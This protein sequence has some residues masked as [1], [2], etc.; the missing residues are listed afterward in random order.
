MNIIDVT[1]RESTYLPNGMDEKK[2]LLFLSRYVEWMQFDEIKGIEICFLDNMKK[3]PLLYDESFILASKRIVGDRFGLIAVVHP[4]QVDLS[5]WNPDIVRLFH[6]VRLMINNTLDQKAIDI[7]DYLHDLGVRVSLNVIYISR[8]D[9]PFVD[10][11]ISVAE[12]HKVEYF[13]LADSCGGCSPEKVNYWIGFIQD[14]CRSLTLNFH[15]H[16]HFHLALAN[17][18]TSLRCTNMVDGSILGYGKGGGN[19][20]LEDIIL[21]YR[22]MHSTPIPKGQI[23]SYYHLVQFLV[24]SIFEG[25]WDQS[26]E[27]F[28]NLL[29][30][31]YDLNLKEINQLEREANGNPDSFIELTLDK[32][33]QS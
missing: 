28:K 18:I 12:E 26:Y 1:I 30:A 10:R 4:D 22:K 27:E 14:R 3:G 29:I 19:L 5:H 2:A 11:C 31:L 21:A 9:E 24:Q 32:Y 8:K 13:C 25:N 15:F 23:L 6:T 17:A 20:A 33:G 7:I 16:D